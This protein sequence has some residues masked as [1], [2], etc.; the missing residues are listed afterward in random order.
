MRS[1][2]ARWSTGATLLRLWPF[3]APEKRRLLVAVVVTMGLTGIEVATPVLIGLAID[4]FLAELN[5]GRVDLSSRREFGLLAALLVAAPLRGVLLAKQRALEGELGQRV[6]ARIRKALW[7]HLQRLPLSYAD[8]RGP[9]RL[10][11]RFIGDSRAVQRMVSQ[12]LVRLSQDLLV[13]AGIL[14]ALTLL[15]WRMALAVLPLVPVQ[16]LVFTRLNPRLRA[17]SRARRR[18]RSRLSAYVASRTAALSVAKPALRN[19]AELERFDSANRGIAKRG[20]RAAATNGTILGLSAAAVALS[21]VLVLIVAVGEAGAGRL[22][23][24]TL[25]TYYALIG[26]LAPIFERVA[27]AN[28]SFQEGRVSVDRITA[29]LAVAPE[30]PVTGAGKSTLLELILRHRCPEAG[31][32]LIDGTDIAEVDPD[33]LRAQIGFVPQRLPLFD[34]TAAENVTIGASREVT[35]ADLERA[36]RLSGADE[37]AAR[38]ADGWETKLAE[39]RR[40]LSE[41]ERQRLALARALL[42]D[43]PILL[44]DEPASA[45]DPAA[46][47]ALGVLLRRLATDKT[48][49][50]TGGRLPTSLPVDRV[51]RL[52]QGRL[53]EGSPTREAVPPDTRPAPA[54]PLRAERR[55]A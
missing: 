34:G 31:R 3:I 10:L 1:L 2:L 23:A 51:Y 45:L 48:V 20:A 8:R 44:L 33:S 39:G 50:V 53:T 35:A 15:N 9:G 22:T 32:I 17:E 49:L 4:G 19:R 24:G 38:L 54:P 25:V 12:G 16:A 26:L 13:A 7:R 43:P 6:T 52:E 40:G 30:V 18:R 37:V 21:G 27:T 41:G 55:P 46:E 29:T 36:A 42:S 47:R 11:L 28:R 5:A 14:V